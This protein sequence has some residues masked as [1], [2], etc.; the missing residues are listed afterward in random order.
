MAA[1]APIAWRCSCFAGTIR[2]PAAKVP[3]APA[4]SMTLGMFFTQKKKISFLLSNDLTPTGRPV[5]ID[6]RGPPGNEM[7][8]QRW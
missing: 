7:I 8:L 1:R 2:G 5:V 6:R 4:I 3:F